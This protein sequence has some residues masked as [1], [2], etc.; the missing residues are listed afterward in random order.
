MAAIIRDLCNAAVPF[1]MA[2]LCSVCLLRALKP[3]KQ[4]ESKDISHVERGIAV[5]LIIVLLFL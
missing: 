1:N 2:Y 5:S 4:W 3:D